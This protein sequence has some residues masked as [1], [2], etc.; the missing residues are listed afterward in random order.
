VISETT[1][2]IITLDH[3]R[4]SDVRE[5]LNITS[6]NENIQGNQNNWNNHLERGHLPQLAFASPLKG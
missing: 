6:T 1:I 5:R 4:N 2:E 3:Q